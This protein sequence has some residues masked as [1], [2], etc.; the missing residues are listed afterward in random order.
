[1]RQSGWMSGGI[2]SRHAWVRLAASLALSTIGSVG[3]WSV[4]VVLPAVQA[5]FGTDRATASLPYTSIML[6]FVAGGVL[7]G[8]L[9]DRRGVVLPVLVGTAS[10]GLG[11]AVTAASSSMLVFA[12]ASGAFIG[13]T[14]ASAVFSPLVADISRWFDRNRG[15]PVALVASGNYLAGAIWPPLLEALVAARGWR[16]TQLIAGAAC[17]VLMLPLALLLRRPVPA[18]SP[19]ATAAAAQIAPRP[20]GLAPNRLQ[21]LLAIAALGCC[22]AMSMPQVHIVAYCVDLGYGPA[23]G[24]EMLARMLAFGI[25]SRLAS[26]VIMDRIGGLAT[27]LLGALLQ[28]VALAFYLPFDGLAALYVVSAVFGLFQGRIV[29]AYAF[30]VR[31]YFPPSPERFPDWSKPLRAFDSSTFTH[32]AQPAVCDPLRPGTA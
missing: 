5:E 9:A 3:M 26:G 8:R 1:M 13:L 12:L 20:L 15:I 16:T 24:A 19:A 4:V 22:V 7:M 30:I 18:E 21:G 10:L 14:G 25:V 27:L 2:E 32:T 28:A 23:Q 17:V 6:G 31:E 11:Y 29:P